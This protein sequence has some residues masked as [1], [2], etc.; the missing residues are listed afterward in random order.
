M[1]SVT[2]QCCGCYSKV[3]LSVHCLILHLIQSRQ[4]FHVVSGIGES[5][6]FTRAC[7]WPCKHSGYHKTN[8]VPNL[9]VHFSSCTMSFWR[10]HAYLLLLGFLR[11]WASLAQLQLILRPWAVKFLHYKTIKQWDICQK[12]LHYTFIVV[13]GIMANYCTSVEFSDNKLR[14]QETK[15]LPTLSDVHVLQTSQ[16]QNIR[17]FCNPFHSA[18][19]EPSHTSLTF[20][21]HNTC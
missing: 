9:M 14:P 4:R 16:T 13:K 3:D 15:S 12:R 6:F 1:W 17:I 2:I 21:S 20:F 18:V 8:S 5:S 10:V 7:S 19:P 11:H